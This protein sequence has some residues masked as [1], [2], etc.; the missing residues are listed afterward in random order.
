MLMRNCNDEYLIE[1][2]GVEQ[3]V[4]ELVKEALPDLSAFCGPR[5]RVFSYSLCGRT[6]F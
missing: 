6:D 1:L 5:L 2:Y 4:R 3:F